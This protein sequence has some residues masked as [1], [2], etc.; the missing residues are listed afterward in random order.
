L[1]FYSIKVFG[2]AKYSEI[3]VET[4]KGGFLQALLRALLSSLK[5]SESCLFILSRQ[6]TFLVYDFTFLSYVFALIL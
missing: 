1:F 6:K 2:S 5:A 4:P 3:M